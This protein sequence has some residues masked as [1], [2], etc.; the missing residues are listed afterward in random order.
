[1]LL[2]VLLLPLLLLLLL[3][4]SLPLLLLLILPLLLLVMLAGDLMG[5]SGGSHDEAWHKELLV[6]IN[7][8]RTII[9]NVRPETTLLQYLRQIGLTGTKLGCGEVSSCRGRVYT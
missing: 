8:R 3:L 5:T 9:R 1:M 2:L 6:Y 4:L 7:G